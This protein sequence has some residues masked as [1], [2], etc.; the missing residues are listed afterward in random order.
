[1]GLIKFAHFR[2]VAAQIIPMQKAVAPFTQQLI[3]ISGASQEGV[4]VG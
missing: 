1:M 3:A 4:A 2:V